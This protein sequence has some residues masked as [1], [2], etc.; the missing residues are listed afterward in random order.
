[1][2]LRLVL[3]AVE[4]CALENNVN[5]ECTPR[6]VYSVLLSIDLESLAVNCDCT[7]L[8]ISSYSVEILTDLTAIAALSCIILEELSE[9]RGLCKVV[10][11]NYLVTFSIKHLSECKTA[12]TTETINSNFN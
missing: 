9:H 2:S 8:V 6:A 12:D 11:S 5:T 4:A 1:M 10:D 7:G 3:R